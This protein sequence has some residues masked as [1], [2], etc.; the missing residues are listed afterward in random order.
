MLFSLHN[1]SRFLVTPLCLVWDVLNSQGVVRR[2][3]A[4]SVNGVTALRGENFVV[5]VVVTGGVTAI[6]KS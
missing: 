2:C 6:P 1:S 3:G 4:N 5:A